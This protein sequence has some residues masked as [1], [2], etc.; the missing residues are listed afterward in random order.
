MRGRTRILIQNI[1]LQTPVLSAHQLPLQR[2]ASMETYVDTYHLA[3]TN[4][5]DLNFNAASGISSTLSGLASSVTESLSLT[6]SDFLAF[7]PSKAKAGKSVW[8]LLT[9]GT[10]SEYVSIDFFLYV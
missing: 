2:D 7:F 5:F 10:E 9:V 1:S 6:C 8:Q 4:F 3:N